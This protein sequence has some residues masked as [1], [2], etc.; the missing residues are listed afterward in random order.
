VI[1]IGPY[2]GGD[3]SSGIDDDET[4]ARVP[5]GFDGYVWTNRIEEIGPMMAERR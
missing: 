2:S 4:L 1:L 3:F 5:N